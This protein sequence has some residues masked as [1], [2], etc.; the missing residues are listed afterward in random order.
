MGEAATYEI[1]VDAAGVGEYTY[2]T[3][4][5]L[6]MAGDTDGFDC[7]GVSVVIADDLI[8]FLPYANV[9]CANAVTDN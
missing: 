9:D 8:D 3:D 5:F 4:D 6:E 2:S 7:F 1:I